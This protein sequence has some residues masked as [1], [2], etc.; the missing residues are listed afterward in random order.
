MKK[1]AIILLICFGALSANPLDPVIRSQINVHR[2]YSKMIDHYQN[3]DWQKLSWKCQDLIADFP[4]SPFAREA[5]Y[6]LGVAHYKLGEFEH[7]NMA[8]SDYLKEELTPK[9]FDQVIR[10]K[11]EI[12]RAFDEGARVHLFGWQKMPKWLPAY[13]EA[14][15]IYDEVI[16][17]LPR[18]DLAAQSLYRKGVI[19]LRMEEY[20]KS[21]EAFQTLIRRF[22]KHPRS[23]DGYVGISEVYLTECD[24]EFPDANK[25]D[26]AEI[27]LR[28]FRYH[29][30]S[31]PRI[32]EAEEKLL[33]MKERLA[34]DLL[35]I[36]EF[37]ERTKKKKAAAI[38]YAT[39][40]KKYPETKAANKSEKR[41][42]VLDVPDV[43]SNKK[44]QEGA[45]VVDSSAE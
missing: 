25:L 7:A 14:L 44:S 13:D 42:K 19:L 5:L 22:P 1:V 21:I 3:E 8:F 40:L 23:P 31:E 33:G 17:T 34:N 38:Y 6:Y 43:Y 20:K 9:F 18:D 41:L 10:Y 27:N 45:I 11:F 35:E 15:E 2:Y 39:I 36:A 28:K 12:A 4:T 30:P 32:T 16:T 26:L 37:Y 24:Q 29:F